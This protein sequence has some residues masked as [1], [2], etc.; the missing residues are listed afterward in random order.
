MPDLQIQ[1][2]IYNGN[3]NTVATRLQMDGIAK[4]LTRKEKEKEKTWK[5]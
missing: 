1:A 4:R 5:T 2:Y 3:L